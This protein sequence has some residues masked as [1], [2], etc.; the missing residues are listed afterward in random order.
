MRLRASKR[1]LEVLFHENG[2]AHFFLT[3]YQEDFHL[4]LVR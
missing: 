4:G 3:E 1:Y 2:Y